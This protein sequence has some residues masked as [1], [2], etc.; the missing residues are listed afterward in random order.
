MS[1]EREREFVELS[2]YMDYVATHVMQVDP[3]SP[4]HPTNVLKGI[5]EG[6]GRSKALEGLR[7]AVNDTVQ[8]LDGKHGVAR[9]LDEALRGNGL[10]GFYE[11]VRRYGSAYRKILK[12]GRIRNETEYY[13]VHGAL[14][15]HA[16]EL[17][18]D[19][20]AV[21]AKLVENFEGTVVSKGA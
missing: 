17:T 16:N 2:G 18:D 14:V 5:V 20:R 19:E 21:I 9:A 13:V 4:V 12:R 10:L 11:V 15:D 1:S 6:Y 3:A 8:M 7:Q